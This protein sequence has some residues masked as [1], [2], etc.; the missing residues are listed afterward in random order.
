ML[1]R[2]YIE[3]N[4]IVTVTYEITEAL[5]LSE[6]F[7]NL[8]AIPAKFAKVLTKHGAGQNS[9]IEDIKSHK[10]RSENGFKSVMTNAMKKSKQQD[11]SGVVIYV[12]DSPLI[13]IAAGNNYFGERQKYTVHGTNKPLTTKK[14]RQLDGTGRWIGGAKGQYV[15]PKYHAWEE[16]SM[17]MTEANLAIWRLLKEYIGDEIN[18]DSF[19]WKQLQP[20]VKIIKVDQKRLEKEQERKASREGTDSDVEGLSTKVNKHKDRE[21]L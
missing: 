8:K 10:I 20:S 18:D 15:P 4:P 1:F 19:D 13:L 16:K 14:S 7:G 12:M 17:N 2:E 3:E 21:S 9:E 11:I 5:L 6:N